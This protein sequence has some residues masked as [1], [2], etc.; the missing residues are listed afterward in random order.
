[1]N[2]YTFPWIPLISKSPEGRAVRQSTFHAFTHRGSLLD[3]VSSK[4]DSSFCLVFVAISEQTIFLFFFLK[5][6]RQHRCLNICRYIGL[7]D[8]YCI[9]ELN[10]YKYKYWD[11]SPVQCL[12]FLFCLL[13]F[14]YLHLVP[15]YYLNPLKSLTLQ[16][17][18]NNGLSIQWKGCAPL[19]LR[20]F[21]YPSYHA[22]NGINSAIQCLHKG[23]GWTS[24]L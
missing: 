18:F 5:V 15:V 17:S 16:E 24:F 21:S 6:A 8:K 13:C 14:S 19:P 4:L 2:D 11:S 20:R 9:C 22:C 10:Q 3:A 7:T 12:P 1:M 23:L